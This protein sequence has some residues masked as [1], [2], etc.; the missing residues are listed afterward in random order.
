MTVQETLPEPPGPLP[1]GLEAATNH[2]SLTQAA[3]R[4]LAL[5]RLTPSPITV[6]PEPRRLPWE[7]DEAH[8]GSGAHS[9]V[10]RQDFPMR[11]SKAV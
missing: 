2:A 6:R 11:Y 5:G 10:G 1:Q 8:F 7:V 3:V 4:L 9:L